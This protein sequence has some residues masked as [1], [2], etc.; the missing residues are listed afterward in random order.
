MKK[1]EFLAAVEKEIISI[2]ENATTEEIGNLD[3]TELK[4]ANSD[5]CIYGQMTGSC[6]NLRSKDLMIKGCTLVFN[7]ICFSDFDTL[8]DNVISVES[9]NSNEWNRG[10]RYT[11][12]FSALET[13]ISL[14]D[15]NNENVIAFL[16][17]EV[18]ELEL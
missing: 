2:K 7:E 11:N 5:N 13:Y 4:P 9:N 17:G 10:W 1:E 3:F 15:S 6:N 8:T 12:Y 18:K 14:D 16:K